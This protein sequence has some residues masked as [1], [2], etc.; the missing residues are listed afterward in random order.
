MILVVS[1]YMIIIT[2][3]HQLNGNMFQGNTNDRYKL[4]ILRKGRGLAGMVMKT[5]K[6]MVIADVDTALS[7]EES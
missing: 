5:G 6:R 1:L 3:H 4:I 7:P 2:L